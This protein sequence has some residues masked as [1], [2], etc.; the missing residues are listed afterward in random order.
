MFSRGFKV[1]AKQRFEVYVDEVTPN[2]D[3]AIVK[4]ETGA[5]C[6]ADLRYYLG[7]RDDKVLDMKYPIS[8]IHEAV[9]R[10][11]KDR[12]GNFSPGD[13][14]LLCP[15][16][17]ENEFL[18]KSISCPELGE[19]Y[20]A[21]AQFASSSIDGFSRNIIA[22]KATNLVRIPDEYNNSI[23]V[24]AELISVVCAALRR[25][26]FTNNNTIG[27]WGDG[28]LGYIL[29]SVLSINHN[30]RIVVIGSHKEKLKK[31]PVDEVYH[32]N[33]PLIQNETLDIAFECIGGEGAE[34][35]INQIIDVINVGGR[36]VLTGVS[37]KNVAINT[38][39]ILEKGLSLYGST[40]SSVDD[41]RSAALLLHNNH[42]R[43]LLKEL[44]LDELKVSNI[45]DYYK[46]FEKEKDNKLLGKYIL[47]FFF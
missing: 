44:I 32:Y 15:N 31:F 5:I 24:F 43:N 6:K 4:I 46:A 27:I 14:V 10:I 40:R 3:E 29:A 37:E 34:S 7:L 22:Y 17:L 47:N 8:L 13:K 11:I 9:G 45:N 30:G 33:D 19:N 26:N 18:E 36:V 35:G 20:S 25:N 41:F 38:R 28:I 23:V 21:Y 1:V 16:I 2:V 42:L 12:T 39:K